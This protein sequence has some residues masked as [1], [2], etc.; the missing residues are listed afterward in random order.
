MAEGTTELNWSEVESGLA[1]MGLEGDFVTLDEVA[2]K[3]WIPASMTRSELTEEDV[4]QG[5][6]AHFLDEDNTTQI[7]VVYVNVEGASLEDYAAALPE[8]GATDIESLVI[9]GLP[10]ISYTV[11]ETDSLSIA[12]TTEAGYILEMTMTPISVEGADVAWY[13]ISSSIMAE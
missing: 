3:L 5:F 11:A 9:N 1:E 8:Y 7:S 12:F 13:I 4:E 2:V 6:I 10:A